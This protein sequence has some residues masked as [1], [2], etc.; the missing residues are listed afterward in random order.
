LFLLLCAAHAPNDA[1]DDTNAMTENTET[2]KC[3]RALCKFTRRAY[4]ANLKFA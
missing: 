3:R 4:A 1:N 2:K